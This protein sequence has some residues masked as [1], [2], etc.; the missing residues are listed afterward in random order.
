MRTTPKMLVLAGAFAT[1]MCGGG[2]D[3]AAEGAAPAPAP[4]P[5]PQVTQAATM[6]AAE[7]LPPPN[8]AFSEFKARIDE[9]VIIRDTVE[10]SLPQLSLT[11]D[12]KQIAERAQLLASGIATARTGAKQ[13]AI[14][15]PV[16]TTE[17]KRIL[18]ADAASRTAQAR[19]D[20]M[21]EVPKTDPQV[22]APYPT[23]S[24]TGPAALAS[25]PPNL[26]LVLPE[27]PDVVEYRF[28]GQALVL[29]DTAANVIVDFLPGVAPARAGGNDGDR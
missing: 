23:D 20:M 2:V 3:P 16:V 10:R 19:A 29:R 27:L 8:A 4:S 1:I 6:P 18:A 26:L 25:F 21:A 5:E 12:P 22:N 24:P 13:G 28:L 15:T 9:Y 7:T 11:R 17:F 14:F